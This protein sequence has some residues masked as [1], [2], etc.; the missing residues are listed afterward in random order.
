MLD[1]RRAFHGLSRK[2]LRAQEMQ[3]RFLD[4]RTERDIDKQVAKLL[5]DLGD[6]EPP[7]RL[8]IVRELLTLDRAYYSSSDGGVLADTVHRL[9]VAGKQVLRRPSILADVVKKLELK[10]LWIPDRKRI[11]IDS[12]LPS[13]K[14][15][16]GEGHEI[17]H[18]IIPWHEVVLHGDKTRTLSLACEQQVEAEA[19]YAT[20]RL[21]FLREAFTERL[22]STALTFDRVKTLSGEFGNTMTSTLWRAV[23]STEQIAFGLVSKHPRDYASDSPPRYFIRSRSFAAQFDRVTEAQIFASLRTFCFGRRGPIGNDEVLFPDDSCQ[24]QHIFFVE[25]FFNGHE[26]LTLG[27]HRRCKS[28]AT[29]F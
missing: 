5:R 16:W 10:A 13:A 28:P 14:Q 26:A 8:E 22:R 2:P 6:P 29:K 21:L 17:S 9:K 25:V 15:R 18:S 23:E 20:G 1:D 19:N 4:G 24:Q 7:L 3:N 27:V 12:D 11:L